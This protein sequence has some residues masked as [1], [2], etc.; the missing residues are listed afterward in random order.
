MLS[1][2]VEIGILKK[3]APAGINDFIGEDNPLRH[4][5]EK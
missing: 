5:Q 3:L 1:E 4:I 2:L